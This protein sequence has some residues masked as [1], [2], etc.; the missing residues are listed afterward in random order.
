LLKS[1]TAKFCT[2]NFLPLTELTSFA[3][4]FA[5]RRLLFSAAERR[6]Y[7]EVFIACQVSFAFRFTQLHHLLAAT[8]SGLARTFALP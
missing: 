4:A 6:D 3:A 5:L 8:S 2:T 7:E 1:G